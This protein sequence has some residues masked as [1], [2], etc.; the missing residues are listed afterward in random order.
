LVREKVERP[1]K[2]KK[3]TRSLGLTILQFTL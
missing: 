3:V 2:E 1:R